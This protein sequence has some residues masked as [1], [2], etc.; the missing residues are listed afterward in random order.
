MNFIK[1]FIKSKINIVLIFLLPLY[2]SCTE[3]V[4]VDLPD[5]KIDKSEVFNDPAT[6]KA[7]LNNLYLNY[8]NS[9]LFNKANTGINFNIS[10]FTDELDY[11]GSNA[12]TKDIFLNTVTDTHATISNWW[13]NSYQHIYA[14]NAFIEG[15]NNSNVLDKK[16]KNTFLGEAYFLRALYYQYLA[17]FFGDIPYTNSTD[18]KFN[19]NLSKTPYN[20]LLL[21][22][23]DDLKL[24]S[25]LLDYTYRDVNKFYIN[26]SSVD[27]LLSENY[28]LQ[29]KYDKA[30]LTAQSLLKENIYNIETDLQATFKKNAK[31][32]L[33]QLSPRSLVGNSATSEALIYIYSNFTTNSTAISDALLNTFDNHD[34]RKENWLKKITLN[35]QDFY[36]VYKYK[37]QNNNTDEFSIIFRIE[38]LYYNLVLSFI[39]QDNLAQA[40]DTLNML[41]QKR[42]LNNLPESSTK[43]ELIDYYLQ[44]S[45]KEFFTENAR[46]FFDL[47]LTNKLEVLQNTKPNFKSYHN[48]LPI[49]S[50]QIEI[51]KNL[52]PN[53]PGY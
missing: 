23:E 6:I 49:P 20:Q 24:A 13:N 44:E 22:V 40:I 10:L 12:S 43:Q 17:L 31:S 19:L 26:K 38:Q 27:I 25:N 34:K 29:H 18:Y 5:T 46:R 39:M 11:Y 4:E 36:Q 32:T 15:V 21:L 2:I 30:E 42:G 47:K 52:S 33:W 35:N 41:R 14:I 53:N 48:L 45:T 51:N 50:K 8:L 16:Q 3:L 1:H 9:S 7:A 28:L 37:N